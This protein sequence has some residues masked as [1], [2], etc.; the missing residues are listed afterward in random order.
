MCIFSEEVHDMIVAVCVDKKMGTSFGGK[1]Q[2]M[3]SELRKDLLREVKE[4]GGRLYVS[5]YTA[6]QFG[7]QSELTVCDDPG[8][9]AGAGD[10]Y[11]AELTP[12]KD[13]EDRIE[14]LIIYRW[15]RQYPEDEKL[16]IDLKKWRRQSRNDFPGS[17]HEKITREVY[18]K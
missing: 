3:D 1:R 2:S 9:Q 18:V 4:S 13:L 15:N 7:D 6:R 8:M 12:L 16:D 17:S 11:F 14:K 10:F 5:P